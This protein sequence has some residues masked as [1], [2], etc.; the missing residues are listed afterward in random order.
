[1]LTI[2]MATPS[3]AET[4]AQAMAAAWQHHPALMA[5]HARKR[6]ADAG[7]DIARSGY[8]PDVNA[9]G[10]IAAANETLRGNAWTP[11]G[12]YS[13][14][15][16]QTLF[17]GF[18]TTSAVD[19]ALADAGAAAAGVLDTERAVLLEAVK[20]YADVLRDRNI[21]A[22]R[23]RDIGML[24]EQVKAAQENL[25]KG[26][27]TLT[28]VAQTR[29]RRAQAT[30]DLITAMAEAEVSAAEYERVVGHPPSKL[31]R[32]SIPKSSL[33]TSLQAALESADRFDPAT[34][35]AQLK[36]KA[37]RSAI[38]RVR[39]DALPQ[40]KARAALE[41]NRGL[42][43][44]AGDRDVASVGLRVSVPIFDGGETSARVAQARE[45]S[46]ALSGDARGAQERARAGAVTA[47]KRLAA[48]RERLV[49]EREAV[50]QNRKALEG[51]REGIRLGQRSM[52]EA[53][54]AQRDVV[55][56][57]VRVGSIERDLL[58]SAYVLLA[59]TGAL[60]VE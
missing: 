25:S 56:A 53:L 13:V 48:A 33:P 40:V 45:L 8:F 57:E 42:S 17:D 11:A 44:L 22:L 14:S 41:G 55:A 46:T 5:E 39:A 51:I 31:K 50:T 30:A 34:Q 3:Q 32:P 47:W 28:D 18:R 1:M 54:D 60:S 49:A 24:D 58:V 7:I 12:N 6:A 9:T 35:R 21:Q 23:K 26:A 19:E 43:A 15:A 20:V 38:E 36:A 52:L 16:E 29:A 4:L 10:E 37:S 27:G 59:A 2:A